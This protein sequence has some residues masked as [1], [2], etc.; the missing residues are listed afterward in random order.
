[1]ERELHKALL[2]K[3]LL[4]TEFEMVRDPYT[5]TVTV[6]F[7]QGAH[8]KELLFTDTQI[9]TDVELVADTVYRHI[10]PVEDKSDD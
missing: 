8:R 10:R 6:F 5:L 1:M 9:A 2:D 7:K 4:E 3:G